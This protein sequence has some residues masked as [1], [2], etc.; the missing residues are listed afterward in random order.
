MAERD[1]GQPVDA[2]VDVGARLGAAGQ[3]QVASARCAAADEHGVVALRHQLLQAV[4]ALA[5]D[6]FDAE[7]EDV[8]GFLVDDFLGQAEFG[9]LAADE[10]ARLGLGV[11]DRDL[12]A[13]LGQVARHRQRGRAGADAGDAL[14]VLLGR[15]LRQAVADIVLVVGGDALEAADRHRLLARLVLDARTAAGRLAR[16]V[17]GASQHAGEDIRFPV[18]QVGIR[19]AAGGDQAD[20][21]GHGRVGRTGPLAVDHFMKV[22]R[23]N[24]IGRTQCSYSLRQWRFTL[25]GHPGRPCEPAGSGTHHRRRQDL[26]RLS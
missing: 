1:R 20:V 2:D 16:A 4:D 7:V 26:S 5:A 19:I 11:E 10:A 6:E 9:D 25:P 21:F 14:A 3:R 24:D 12:V 8:A 15:R 22:V 23:A 13:V 18:D 17:A